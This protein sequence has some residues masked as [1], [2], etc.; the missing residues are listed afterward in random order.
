MKGRKESKQKP[1]CEKMR[2]LQRLSWSLLDPFYF[3]GICTVPVASSLLLPCYGKSLLSWTAPHSALQLVP[4]WMESL[5]AICCQ[6][7]HLLLIDLVLT[8][9][10]LHPSSFHGQTGRLCQHP[11]SSALEVTVIHRVPSMNAEHMPGTHPTHTES[12]TLNLQGAWIPLLRQ[13]ISLSPSS[14]LCVVFK[15]FPKI[16]STCHYCKLR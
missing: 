4:S 8:L 12:S 13:I 14:C 9:K 15:P 1:V 10:F 6:C 16:S 2:F 3:S 5:A 11:C 7:L